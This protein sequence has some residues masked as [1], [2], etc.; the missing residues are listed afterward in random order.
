MHKHVTHNRCHE[1]FAT[2]RAAVLAFLR[3]KVPRNW[4]RFCN[5]VTDSFRIILPE[6]FW[7]LT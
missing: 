3:E 6:D 2:F 7:I 4:H 1:T 5:A